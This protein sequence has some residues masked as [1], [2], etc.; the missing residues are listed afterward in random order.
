MKASQ[1]TLEFYT[2][3]AAMTSGGAHAA[4]FAELPS[5]VPSLVRVVQGLL[6]HQ[7]WA[8]A[9]GVE[10]SDERRGESHLRPVDRMLDRVLA[11]D[12]RPFSVA[13]P[14]DAR[15]VGNCR[16]F[17]VLLTALLRARGIPARARCGFA[18]YFNTGTFVDHWV[19]EHWS[20]AE[21]RW[22][23]VDAQIDDVQRAALKPDFDAL[24]V[25]RDRFVVA[26]D[27][28]AKGRAGEVDPMK[29]GFLD[30]GGL[31]FIDGN[32]VRD[33]AALNNMEMLPWDCWGA[34]SRPEEAHGDDRLALFDGLAAITRSPDACF[35]DLRATY[36]GD[37]RLRVPATVLNAVLNREDTI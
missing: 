31:W 30:E 26:G 29:F 34:M 35:A 6:L 14:P 1:D 37:E 27:A 8:Q 7:H 19:C 3:P 17:T 12:A 18:G 36:D 13:R 11:L 15:L 4:R 32:L 33:L 10:L 24:D 9:Y 22:V 21:A 20:A 5:D 28:W 25:P 2:R 16:H 23:L